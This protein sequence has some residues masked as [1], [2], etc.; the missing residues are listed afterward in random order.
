MSSPVVTGKPYA[1]PFRSN[2]VSGENAHLWWSLTLD[3]EGGI[4][5]LHNTQTS[6]D[7]DNNCRVF[8]SFSKG[9]TADLSS[10]KIALA[11]ASNPAVIFSHNATSGKN[12][13]IEVY[14]QT[15]DGTRKLIGT[16]DYSKLS[17]KAEDWHRSLFKIPAEMAKADYVI[18]TA[19][20]ARQTHTA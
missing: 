7:G 20:W 1:L 12:C 16:V 4:G 17:G 11:G 5:F 19:S 13:S 10:G 15:P 18:L 6:S 14:A 2:F 3:E 9:G 8:T